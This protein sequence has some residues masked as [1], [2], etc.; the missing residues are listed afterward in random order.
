MNSPIFKGVFRRIEYFWIVKIV[1]VKI[2]FF[3]A[4]ENVVWVK[5]VIVLGSHT[6][7]YVL[8]FLMS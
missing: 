8:T 3:N 2:I 6:H 5:F 7:L 4:K 1:G